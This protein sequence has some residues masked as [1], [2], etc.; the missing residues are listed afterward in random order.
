MTRGMSVKV[1][2]FFAMF[3][4][5]LMLGPSLAHLFEMPNKMQLAGDHY[6]TVQQ[7]Y[8]GWSRTGVLVGGALLTT[9]YLAVLLRGDTRARRFAWIT[10]GC[11]VA[12]QILF[13]TFTFPT[14]RATEN[15]TEMPEH[16]VALRRQWEYSHAGGA[17]LN[18]V[19]HASLVA[20]LLS[21]WGRGGAAR[22]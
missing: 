22:A 7:I 12:G 4:L 11:I 8:A 13:W 1:V 2:A 3:F 19:G 14:N 9:V 10:V 18:L 5:G 17:I 16:W 21:R 6:F 15:W 20:A